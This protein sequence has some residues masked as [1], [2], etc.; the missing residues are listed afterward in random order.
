MLS[1]A[2][3]FMLR[4]QNHDGGFGSYEARRA[5]VSLEWLNPSEMFGDSMME[6]SFVECTA[7]CLAALATCQLWF[8]QFRGPSVTQAISRGEAWLRLNQKIDGAWRGVWGILFIYGIFF[9]IRGLM[10]TGT[11]PSDL[12]VRLACRWLLDRQRDDGGWGE[13]HSSCSSGRY[14]AHDESQVIQTAW[15]LTALLTADDSNWTAISRGAQF[16]LNTQNTDVTWPKQDMAGVFFHTALLD[17]A[18]YRQYFPLKALGLYEQ[19]RQSREALT[20]PVII[21]PAATG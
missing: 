2:V 9:G 20:N 1:D 17:Y 18:L 13:H 4:G 12:A 15:A 11:H 21:R 14:I 3:Q 19:R 10:A 8:P 5:M 7:S 16:L 6:Y